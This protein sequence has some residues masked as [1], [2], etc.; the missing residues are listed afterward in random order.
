[1][2]KRASIA[3]CAAA[4]CATLALP[5]AAQAAAG[6]STYGTIAEFN[7]NPPIPPG[8]ELLFMVLNGTT[9]PSSCSVPGGFYMVVSTD[10]QKRMFA[11]L[12][13]AKAAQQRL[14][15]YVTGTC[16]SWGYAEVTGLALE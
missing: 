15:F 1:M 4:L 3:A 6:W 16:H 12:L 11:T 8:S 13:A 2:I 9:N 5:P 7:L 10:H 14:R